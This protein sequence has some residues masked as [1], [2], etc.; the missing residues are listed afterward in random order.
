MFQEVSPYQYAVLGR[1]R[2]AE[3][4]PPDVTLNLPT[5]LQNL[6]HLTD[7]RDEHQLHLGIFQDVGDLGN[8]QRAIDGHVENANTQTR[9]IGECPLRGILRKNRHLVPRAQAQ[10]LETCRGGAHDFVDLV[11]GDA[12]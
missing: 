12:L 3:H 11:E 10:R 9:K 8:R 6:P 4:H 5:R 1:L 7:I 2:R